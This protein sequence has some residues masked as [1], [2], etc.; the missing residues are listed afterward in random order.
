MFTYILKLGDSAFLGNLASIF[1]TSKKRN[2][3]KQFG[4]IP[5]SER[6]SNKYYAEYARKILKK[7]KLALVRERITW[8]RRQL[9]GVE[10][11]IAI[12]TG[13]EQ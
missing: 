13:W 7:A 1:S 2:N 12:L 10:E 6:I 5:L 11:K 3:Y 9:C 4:I 8:S